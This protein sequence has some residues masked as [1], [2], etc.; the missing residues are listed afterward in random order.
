MKIGPRIISSLASLAAL[1]AAF[2]HATMAGT[3]HQLAVLW[4]VERTSGTQ[5]I[6]LE[7]F[8]IQFN[9]LLTESEASFGDKLYRTRSPIA[10]NTIAETS[11]ETLD[12]SGFQIALPSTL[13][14][15]LMMLTTV[16]LLSLSVIIVVYGTR[17]AGE[18]MRRF[19]TGSNA[20]TTC[21]R[22]FASLNTLALLV[23]RL[24][25]LVA[26]LSAPL[27]AFLA[28]DRTHAPLTHTHGYVLTPGVLLWYWG[29]VAFLT[30]AFSIGLSITWICITVYRKLVPARNLCA[31]CGYPRTD[32]SICTECG[33]TLGICDIRRRAVIASTITILATGLIATYGVYRRNDDLFRTLRW[34]IN[35]F[36]ASYQPAP[37]HITRW[38]W[39]TEMFLYLPQNWSLRDQ[40]I[41]NDLVWFDHAGLFVE[42][43]RYRISIIPD[44]HT[45]SVFAE[46]L[47]TGTHAS[48]WSAQYMDEGMQYFDLE[49]DDLEISV[50]KPT[51]AIISQLDS[52]ER[53]S[54]ARISPRVAWQISH[55]SI[56][57]PSNK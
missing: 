50:A 40:F 26:L 24:A 53:C 49:F 30:W 32:N 23:R 35:G 14:S 20:A 44:K 1:C 42:S 8:Y 37:T 48:A 4:T 47:T 12:L 45:L 36:P 5:P 27:A 56:T 16:A 57:Q 33:S 2:V 10:P 52:Y 15:W 46:D 19:A 39:N 3:V 55:S 21:W 41:E 11:I 29:I 43:G 34:L 7:W 18:Q 22:R 9:Y 51:D 17:H 13:T 31:V 6:H 28:F 38:R 25:V 54:Q